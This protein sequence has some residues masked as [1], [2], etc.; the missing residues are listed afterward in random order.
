MD[1]FKYYFIFL[2]Y[3]IILINMISNLQKFYINSKNCVSGTDSNF[4]YNININKDVNSVALSYWSVPT[5][6][7]N[8]ST[9]SGN[10]IH[11]IEDVGGANNVIDIVLPSG[12]YTQTQLLTRATALFNA[13]TQ[14]A[15]VYAFTV[16]NNVNYSDGKIK[17]T[18]TDGMNPNIIPCL[19]Y[20]DDN[21]LCELF[22]FN[23]SPD[24]INNLYNF[25]N[26]LISPN[27]A[28][29]AS[30]N[31]LFLQSDIANNFNNNFVIKNN[32][33][34]STNNI[35]GTIYTAFAQ[36]F[37]YVAQVYDMFNTMTGINIK[38]SYNFFITDEDNDIVDLHGC[39]TSFT[40]LCFNYH[41]DYYPMLKNLYLKY[42]DD[43][44]KNIYK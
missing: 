3:T 44:I 24:L 30:K 16:N 41:Y 12:N 18:C 37:T 9:T 19:I 22:G 1:L 21:I 28:N 32:K 34:Y 43:N 13:G 11:L 25:T 4:V 14:N 10:T 35:L 39:D 40:L 7:Y 26:E 38:S 27:V 42:K 23:P 20:F 2:L 33:N 36:P 8:V 15:I 5:S 6:F 17:L 29:M 31:A